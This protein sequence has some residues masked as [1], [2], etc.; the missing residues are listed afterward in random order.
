[1]LNAPFMDN[2]VNWQVTSVRIDRE[3]WRRL[4]MRAASEGRTTSAL[5][6]L[7]VMQYLL[8]PEP[9]RRRNEYDI[10]ERRFT[11]NTNDE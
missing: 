11:R 6:S 1:M 5:L 7:A 8:Q 10:D 3:L 2:S 4:K 9:R